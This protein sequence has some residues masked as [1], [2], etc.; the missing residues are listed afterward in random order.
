MEKKGK[1]EKYPSLRKDDLHAIV[2]IAYRILHSPVFKLMKATTPAEFWK[3]R[4]GNGNWKEAEDAAA[5]NAPDRLK[6]VLIA[7]F[8]W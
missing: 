7:L 2:R 8:P 1:G 4:L 6:T 5:S 3:S